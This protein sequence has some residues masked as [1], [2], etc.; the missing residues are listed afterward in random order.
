V[1]RNSGISSQR[2]GD[3]YYVGNLPWW[4]LLWY[5]LSNHP[6]WLATFAMLT[7]VLLALVLWNSLRWHARRRLQGRDE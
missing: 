7:V 6:V 5:H 2:V 3:I 1:L 4:M